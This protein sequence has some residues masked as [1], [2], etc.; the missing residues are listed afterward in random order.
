M[1]DGPLGERRVGMS[2]QSS[3]ASGLAHEL[4]VVFRRVDEASVVELHLVRR[5]HA[6]RHALLAVHERD[7]GALLEAAARVARD[8][9]PD[10]DTSRGRPA[11]LANGVNLVEDDDVQSR[12]VA[13]LFIL[14]LG[15]VRWRV[16]NGLG[17]ALPSVLMH[18]CFC[19]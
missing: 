10:A 19:K 8:A 4:V 1:R 14:G 5:D 16:N 13:L 7:D 17:C 11:L 3:A 12:R 6:R 9:V 2:S 18:L 15:C